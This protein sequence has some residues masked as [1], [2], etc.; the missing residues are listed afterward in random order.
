MLSNITDSIIFDISGNN[1]Y[2]IA[3]V[4]FDKH[5]LYSIFAYLFYLIVARLFCYLLT[6]SRG[7]IDSTYGIITDMTAFDTS[8][9]T[10]D[11]LIFHKYIVYGMFDIFH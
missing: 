10:V 11:I 9:G 8:D 2:T 3:F 1:T 5:I 7:A 4:S 6:K